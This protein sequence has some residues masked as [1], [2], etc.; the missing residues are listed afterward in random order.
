MYKVRDLKHPFK[1]SLQSEVVDRGLEIPHM[2]LAPGLATQLARH[3]I[4]WH[5]SVAKCKHVGG[6]TVEV[7][8]LEK[9]LGRL[10]DLR[11]KGAKT[12]RL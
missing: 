10:V 2:I 3:G 6:I 11:S 9:D 7:L 4:D 1:M 12:V 5:V 8:Q